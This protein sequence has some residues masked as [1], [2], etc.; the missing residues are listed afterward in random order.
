MLFRSVAANIY[1]GEIDLVQPNGE[2]LHSCPVGLSYDDGTNTVL[3]AVLTNS[4][5]QLVGSNQV[6]YTNAFVGLDADIIYSYTRSGLEQDIVL[7]EQPPTPASLNLSP[8]TTR[9]QVLTEFLNPPQPRQATS[10]LPE[11]AGLALTDDTLDFGTMQMVPGKAFKLGEDSP[12]ARVGKSWVTLQGRQFLVE[13]VPV[14]ALAEQLENLP[15]PTAQTVSTAKARL[16]SRNPVLPPQHLAKAGIQPLKLARTGVSRKPGVVL[17]YL[18]VNSSL[19]NYTFQGDTTYYISGTTYSYG[20]N[21][22]EGGT[23]I[24]YASSGEIC[25]EAHTGTTPSVTFKSSAY[26]P[27]VFTAKDDNSVGDTISGSTG[28]P[29]GHYGTML[30]LPLDISLTLSAFR[31]SYAGTGI[32]FNSG[33]NNINLYNAQFLNCQNGVNLSYST[34]WIENALFADTSNGVVSTSYSTFN[35]QNCT[36]NGCTN[37][38][39]G[40]NSPYFDVSVTVTNCILSN[41]SALTNGYVNLSGS[42]NGFYNCANFGSSAVTNNFYPFH[43]VGGGKYY[44][45]NGCSFHNVGTTNIDPV[46]LANLATKTTYPPIAFTN[47]T[48]SS[49]TNFSPQAQRDNTNNPDL[50]YHYDPIDYSFGGCFAD[51]NFTFSNGTAVGWFRTSSGWEHAGYG[52]DMGAGVTVLFSGIA[53]APDYWVRLNTVQEQDYTAGY[54]QAG[55]ETWVNSNLPTVSG[56]FLRCSAMAGELR[57]YFSDDY[58]SIQARMVNSEFW[59]GS[60]DAYGDYMYFTNCLMQRVDMELWNGSAGNARI[61]WDCTFFGGE[62]DIERTSGGSAFVS[63]RNSSFDGTSISTSDYYGSNPTYSDYN[64]NA[65]TNSTD[66]FSIGGANDVKGTIFNFETSWFGNY[67]LPSDSSLIDMGSTTANLLGLYYFTTQT[68]QTIEADSPVD[69]GYHYVAT[70]QYGNPLATFND[71]IPNYLDDPKGNGLPNWW[72]LEY[73]ENTDESATNSDFMDNTLLYDYQNGLYPNTI[74]FAVQAANDYVDSTNAQ[75][76]LIIES[77]VPSFIALSLDDTNY[78]GDANWVAFTGTNVGVNL[79]TNQG[80]HSI[81]IGLKGP[82]PD[83]IITW[84]WIRLKL[85]LTPPQIVITNPVASNV[86]Q[87]V[88]QL[89]GYSQKTLSSISYDLTNAFGLVT[90]QQILILNKFYDTNSCEFTTNTFQS[91]DMSM[92]QGTNIL[93]IHAKDLAGNV[94]T[95]N[96]SLTLDYSSKTNPPVVNLYWPQDGTQISGT[97]FTLNGQVNDPTAQIGAQIVNSDGNTNIAQGTVDRDGTFWIE[98]LPLGSGTNR[99][100]ITTTD[101]A[102]NMSTTNIYVAGSSLYLSVNDIQPGQTTVTG[103]ISTNTYAVWVNGVLATQQSG[104]NW[105]ADNVLTPPNNVIVQVRAI[106]YTDNNGNGSGNGTNALSSTNLNNPSSSMAVDTEIAIQPPS[107]IY[108]QSYNWLYNESHLAT[109]PEIWDTTSLTWENGLGGIETNNVIVTSIYY[110]ATI[111]WPPN[112]WP[113]PYTPGSIYYYFYSSSNTYSPINHYFSQVEASVSSTNPTGSTFQEQQHM[114][115]KL[116]TGGDIGST[117]QNLWVISVNATN[118]FNPFPFDPD[119][120]PWYGAPEYVSVP[121]QE[122]TVGTL[123]NPDTNGNIYVV[124]PDNA[125]LDIT[126]Q[127]NGSTY[128]TFNVSAN[129]YVP[130]NCQVSITQIQN[131]S[132]PGFIPTS[133]DCNDTTNTLYGQTG[134]FEITR[135]GDILRPLFVPY[136]LGGTALEGQQYELQGDDQAFW[137]GRP[138][139][140]QNYVYLAPGQSS[141]IVPVSPQ[142]DPVNYGTVSIDISIIPDG[143]NR[144]GVGPLNSPPY[145]TIGQTNA[146]VDVSDSDVDIW[147]PVFTYPSGNPVPTNGVVEGYGAF[148]REDYNPTTGYGSDVGSGPFIGVFILA[149][150]AVLGTDFSFQSDYCSIQPYGSALFLNDSD[151]YDTNKFETMNFYLIKSSFCIGQHLGIESYVTN[152]PFSFTVLPSG[153]SSPSYKPCHIFTSNPMSSLITQFIIPPLSA[154]GTYNENGFFYIVN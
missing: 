139:V 129:K 131:A 105:E 23:V 35:V 29:S 24:K 85:D 10:T 63:V 141:I 94:T 51:A 73:F 87:P 108:V 2:R 138:N 149:T 5:G 107:G 19:T 27:V 65:Y 146:T 77:G 41:E 98:N 78:A 135:T 125:N 119:H 17:D 145:Y 150:R 126:P 37:F 28:S 16:I 57:S 102:G 133:G 96:F 114:D 128:Y 34:A 111:N 136:A 42:D 43:T 99:L 47:V 92:T 8:E 50:G 59:G 49:P 112:L 143:P 52:I 64:Y 67:Y 76:Q 58:G 91:F 130:G 38:A 151:P 68:N 122:I 21:T 103:T 140:S 81:W 132:E 39:V 127:V 95:T 55:I 100:T 22:F 33:D 62:Y 3:I 4:I 54:G 84:Q 116:A 71:G 75:V 6:I 154:L 110:P 11:Q 15:V 9:L 44:L 86:T 74:G 56:Q 147:S 46:L 137:F 48:F 31:M 90:N 113:E 82:A 89:C 18:T 134:Y 144:A 104:N 1:G 142:Y 72:E 26:R 80:W 14:A 106:P 88:I 20:T 25:I 148:Y 79:S 12:S 45:T 123:G 120:L 153:G 83:A 152:S 101:V 70:D 93:T 53:T 32:E 117:G 40:P 13:A 109:I 66:P 121:P 69:I 36:F 61:T 7:R 124:L 60:L 115:M 30:Y 118:V 97:N